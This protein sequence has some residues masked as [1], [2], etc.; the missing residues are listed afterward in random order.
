MRFFHALTLA[1][2]FGAALVAAPE[3]PFTFPTTPP[4]TVPPTPPPPSGTVVLRLDSLYVINAKVD[5]S[6]RGY[7]AGL[8]RVTKETGPIKIRGKFIDGTGAVET[9]TYPGPFVFIVEAIGTGTVDIVSTPFGLKTDAEIEVKTILVDTGTAPI[10]PPNPKPPEPVD[11]VTKVDKIWVIVVE[12]AA[13]PRTVETAKMLNDPFWLTLK[14]KHDWR[15]YLSDAKPAIDNKYTQL[16]EEVGYP[17]CIIL[18]AANGKVL[19]K[20]KATSA[21]VIDAAV[22]RVAK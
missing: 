11:P 21:A 6:V 14:P 9:K 12:Q 16:A 17:A 7:P 20:F 13:A 10:P 8:V 4:P 3:S 15:H 22:K 1:V 18:D 19:D 5:S 2:A